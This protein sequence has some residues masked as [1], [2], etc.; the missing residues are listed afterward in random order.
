MLQGHS[1]HVDVASENV[2]IVDVV[3]IGVKLQ[4]SEKKTGL[5]V[6]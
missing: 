5:T 2:V 6:L 4:E 3:V 1:L